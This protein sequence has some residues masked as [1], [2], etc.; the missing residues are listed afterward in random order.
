MSTSSK[1]SVEVNACPN[2][3]KSVNCYTALM[4]E[5]IATFYGDVDRPAMG[6]RPSTRVVAHCNPLCWTPDHQA[7][8][9]EPSA[10]EAAN[11]RPVY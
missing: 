9:V 8:V 7:S 6:V 2:L 10:R 4:L 1:G 3:S 11:C 5:E